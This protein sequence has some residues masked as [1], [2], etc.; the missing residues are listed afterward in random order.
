MIVDDYA[1]MVNLRRRTRDPDVLWLCDAYENLLRQRDTENPGA[2]PH[3][4]GEPQPSA[5]T[6]QAA[7][8]HPPS[9]GF[10]KRAYQRWAMRLRRLAEKEAGKSTGPKF[11]KV[12]ERLKA[13]MPYQ[14]VPKKPKKGAKHAE[15]AGVD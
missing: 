13:A 1:R 6:V 14:G 8:P 5:P 3:P 7:A 2:S 12:F 4:D 10:D 15:A 9:N 11:K